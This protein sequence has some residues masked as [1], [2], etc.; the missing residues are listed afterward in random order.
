MKK[1]KGLFTSNYLTKKILHRYSQPIGVLRAEFLIPDVVKVT[2]RIAI[3]S[4]PLVNLT[5][6]I[7]PYV[8]RR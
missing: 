7:S 2:P 8:I 6:I 4:L 5:D 3:T 1:G